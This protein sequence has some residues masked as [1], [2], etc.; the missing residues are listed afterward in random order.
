MQFDDISD[1]VHDGADLEKQGKYKEALEIYR[2]AVK[3]D[4]GN[5]AVWWAL[6]DLYVRSRQ[7]NAAIYCFEQVLKL[8]HPNPQLTDWLEKYKAAQP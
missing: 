3:Q 1:P 5:S 2:E 8:D 6:G 4:P 7:K